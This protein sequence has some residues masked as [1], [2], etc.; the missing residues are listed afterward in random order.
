MKFREVQVLRNKTW[1]FEQFDNLLK[2][3]IFCFA[4]APNNIFQATSEP[5]PITD[6]DG[7]HRGNMRIERKCYFME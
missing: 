1:Y 4:D 7:K 3:D 6:F 2:D 5:V